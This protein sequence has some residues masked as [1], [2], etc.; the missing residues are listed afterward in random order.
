MQWRTVLYVTQRAIILKINPQGK[1]ASIVDLSLAP[2]LASFFQRRMNVR[3]GSKA[4]ICSASTHVRFTPNSDRK[5]G[6]HNQNRQEPW[7]PSGQAPRSHPVEI[8]P[9][10][11]AGHHLLH[12]E[13]TFW[14]QGTSAFGGKADIAFCGA[15]VCF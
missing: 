13:R 11:V 9:P 4:D 2:N 10:L 1:Y 5:S 12:T 15:N 8:A 7:V 14:A 6:H 3:F